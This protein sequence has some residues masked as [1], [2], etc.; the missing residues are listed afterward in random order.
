MT[1]Y[2][3]VNEGD[4]GLAV[5]LAVLFAVRLFVPSVLHLRPLGHLIKPNASEGIRE[6]ETGHDRK[7]DPGKNFVGVIG[8]R[9]IVKQ[10]AFR[11]SAFRRGAIQSM[12][13]YSV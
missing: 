13:F 5:E 12:R 8:T 7:A 11:N 3:L 1:Y 6:H 10:K 4:K 2:C 9:D